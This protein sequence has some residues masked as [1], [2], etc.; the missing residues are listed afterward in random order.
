V[1]TLLRRIDRPRALIGAAA[2]LGL[3]CLAGASQADPVPLY[4]NASAPVAQRVA[5]LLSRMTLEEKVAQ[6]STVWTN[7]TDMLDANFEFDRAKARRNFPNGIGEFARP[8]DIHGPESP[9][10]DPHRDP[11]RTVALVNAVQHWAMED[12]RLGVPVMFHEEG[13]HGYAAPEATSFPQAIAMASSWDPAMVR[14]VNTIVARELRVRGVDAVLSPVVDVARDPR[15][16]RIEETFGE[17]PYLVGEMGVAAVLGLQGE[18]LPLEDGH[19]F[20]TLKHMTGHGQPESGTNVG[21]APY[22]VR[23]LREFFFPPFEQVVHRTNIRRVMASYNE[24]DGVPSHANHWLLHDILRGEWGY[25]GAVVS[26]YFA[27]EQLA[28]VHHVAADI[29][30][31]AVLAL[32]AGVDVDLPDGAAY[33]TLIDSVRAGR[34]TQA[35]IDAAV[36]RVLETKFLAGLFEHPYADGDAAEALTGN[37]DARDVALDAARRSI[38]LLKNDGDLLPLDKAGVRT[39]AVI[40]PNAA[41]ERIG[42]YSGIPRGV[43]TMLEGIQAE[44]GAGV[45]VVTAEGVRITKSDDWWADTV[46]LADPAENAQLI[47]AAVATARRADHIVLVLGDTEQT[48][49]EG[50]AS[51]HLGDRDDLDL[52]GQQ[53][54]LANAIFALHKPTVVVLLNGRPP[55]YPNIAAKAQAIVEGW[56]L[57]QE[58]GTAMADVLFGDVNPGGKLP[59]T[60][61]RNAGQLPDFYNHK[62]SAR[63]GYLFDSA[64]PLWPFGWGL[65]YTTFSISPPRLSATSIK[66]DGTVQVSVDVRNTGARAGDEVVQLYI[67]DQVSSVTRP[68]LELKRFQRVS[69]APGE[70]RTLTFDVGPEQLRFWDINMH[71]VV[72]PGAFDIS[73]GPNSVSLQTAVLTVTN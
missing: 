70:A 33:R 72:E 24:I 19:V 52:V 55:S 10:V 40:G 6:I 20:A 58:G 4:K 28:D 38:V 73:V 9:R 5:D 51:S 43:V 44:V 1:T 32:N 22:S 12:T 71:R 36:A 23:T 35:Q 17:D 18:A 69:L 26:D 42:G 14:R 53:N 7:K 31:A 50:W 60:V 25:T 62:P 16:G 34:V 39:L 56:Y 47:R 59:V 27:I 11:R 63:R 65:S 57:G 13:L 3:A 67:R 8:Q 37:Q 45:H 30:S 54:D 48:S 64:E 15:W 29:P 21:P 61:A 68:V 2:A 46:E 66:P 41:A 49:R